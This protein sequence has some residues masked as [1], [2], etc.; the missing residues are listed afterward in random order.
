[1]PQG[2]TAQGH[3]PRRYQG[4]RFSPTM[5]GRHGK[6][7]TVDLYLAPAVLQCFMKQIRASANIGRRTYLMRYRLRA[8]TNVCGDNKC[9]Q[10]DNKNNNGLPKKP[11]FG[12]RKERFPQVVSFFLSEGWLSFSPSEGC[13]CLIWVPFTEDDPKLI[14]CSTA[15]PL[16]GFLMFLKGYLYHDSTFGVYPLDA[17]PSVLSRCEGPRRPALHGCCWEAFDVFSLIVV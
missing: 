3:Y 16:A 17:E 7:E 11:V 12:P 1:M 5:A 13:L 14:F 15:N 8:T 2:I 6:S 9:K 4:N 10:K